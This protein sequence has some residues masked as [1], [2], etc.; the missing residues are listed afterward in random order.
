MKRILY[1]AL[2]ALL[3]VACG[4]KQKEQPD[5]KTL[6]LTVS[7]SSLS[8]TAEDASTKFISVTTTGSW[9]ATPAGNWIHLDKNS[10]NGD[11]SISVTVDVNEDPI[12]LSANILFISSLSGQ[13]KQASVQVNQSANTK[14]QSV[15]IVPKPSRFDGTKR[16][17]TTYQLL[18]YSFADSDGDG[19]GDFKGIQNK[20]DYLDGLGVTALWLSPAHPTSSYHAYDVNDYYS[21]NPLYAVGEKTT[22]KAEAD[23][24][25]LLAA[26][27][28]KGIGIYMDYVLNHSGKNNPWFQE[29][30]ADPKSPYR[31]FYF[32]S[33]NPSA[34]YKSF[35]MLSGTTY[36]AD[37]WKQVTSGSPKMSISKTT[38]AVTTGN[39]D[40]NL[41]VWKSG[42]EGK[43]VKFVNDGNGS[44]HLVMEFSGTTG[45]LLR[46]YM[47]WD[48]GS[49]FGAQT[50]NTT[51]KE[52]TPLDLVA[53]GADIS[54]TGTGRYRIDLTNVSTETLYYMGCFSESMPDLN[55]G[56]VKEAENNSTF[57]HLAASADKWIEMG[58]DG[59]RL[60]AVKHICGG[61]SSYSETNNITLLTKWYDHCN[62]TYKAAGH[63]GNIFMVA[64]AWDGHETEKNYYKALT[65][66]FEFDYGYALRDMLGNGYASSF[67]SKVA[68]FVTDHTAKRADAVTSFFLSNHDQNRFA[69]EIGAVQG[70]N[71][72]KLKQAAAIL[73][74]GPGKPFVYQGEELGYYGTKDGGDEYVRTPIMW[75]KAGKECAKKGVNN[76]VDNAMLKADISVEAQQE[77]DGSMLKVYQTWSTLRNTYPALAE[78]EMSATTLTGNSIA[79][80]YMTA[81]SQKLL[82]IHNVATTEKKVTVSDS[83]EKPIALLGTASYAGQELTLGPNS[84][85][86]FEL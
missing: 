15:E 42:E 6:T 21:L 12:A 60:D 75:D 45:I 56:N 73:L 53:E 69:S 9:T 25:D 64:E 16:A 5:T 13:E 22:E 37:E 83:M 26:A 68:G 85:V 84:S 76:K 29:A 50:G 39:C 8:F 78:G 51:L 80:W 4:E 46:K 3:L 34:D 31:D 35:P 1:L 65:S 66:C 49:K 81:G 54:F 40:W 20:L 24:K 41:W 32:F 11:A 74:S 63:S 36:K 55:Y 19:V 58:I 70:K 14:P 38:E 59:L 71:T 52:G 7:P 18:I 27:H 23:F 79:A 10:G 62:A 86:I 33:T 30:L 72:G 17:S 43:A 2:A 82:V 47:N 77:T 44:Y 57:Q 28:E 48:S 67:A 61:I